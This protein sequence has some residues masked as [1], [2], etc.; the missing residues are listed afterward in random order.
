MVPIKL[1]IVLDL[2]VEFAESNTLIL[3]VGLCGSWARGT[4]G[5]ESDIDLSII[6]KDQLWFKQTDWMK[7]VGFE[8]IGERIDYFQD[9]VYG[10]VRSRH[11][12][13]ESGTE[14]EFSFADINWAEVDP[15]DEGTRKVVSDGY[16]ILYD[17]NRILKKLLE[18]VMPY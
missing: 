3:A 5:P 1:E 6:V 17:P 4:A 9:E 16:R 10:R 12:F 15:L 13:L 14:I 8:R 11:V 18:K 2:I 7:E